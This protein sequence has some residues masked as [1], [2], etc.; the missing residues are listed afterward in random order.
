MKYL[1]IVFTLVACLDCTPKLSPD[2]NWVGRRWVL[3]EMKGVPV[4]LSGGRRD[5]YINFEAAEKRFTG[6]GGCNQVSGNYSL[7]KKNI[8]FGEVISTKM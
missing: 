4:Q 7:D 6:N 1:F 8:H 2:S 5:A 3:T